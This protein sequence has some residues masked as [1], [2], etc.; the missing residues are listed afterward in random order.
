MKKLAIVSL[1]TLALLIPA[2][3]GKKEV[4]R[5]SPEAI[6]IKKAFN[7][8]EK[9]KNAYLRKDRYALKQYCTKEGYLTLISSMKDFDSAAI[10]FQLRW[11]DIK[12]D[13]IIL[14]IYWRGTWRLRGKMYEDSGLGAF[15]F[16]G[17][18]PRLSDILRANPFSNP[19]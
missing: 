3:G 16:R 17:D 1:M 13:K 18:P 8:A 7:V 19:L 5:P 15:A 6:L 14:Y 10:S 9:I 4:K 2:C 11:A 12:K